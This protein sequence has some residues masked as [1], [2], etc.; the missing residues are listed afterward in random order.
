MSGLGKT[1]TRLTRWEAPRVRYEVQY[2]AVSTLVGRNQGRSSY[3][4]A[5][6]LGGRTF[7]TK[8]A[9]VRVCIILPKNDQVH[10]GGMIS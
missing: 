10:I 8:F 7:R 1:W 5:S 9:A 6:P 2:N 4:G 3:H